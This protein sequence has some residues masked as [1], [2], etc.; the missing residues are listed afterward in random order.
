MSNVQPSIAS[1]R[2]SFKKVPT[3][4]YVSPMSSAIDCL[5]VK[6]PIVFPKIRLGF[7]YGTRRSFQCENFF[8]KTT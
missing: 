5:S 4:L 1:H 3:Y 8:F 7:I 2:N 6:H